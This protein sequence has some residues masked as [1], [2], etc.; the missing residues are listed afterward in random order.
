MLVRWRL[1]RRVS[2]QHLC[3]CSQSLDADDIQTVPELSG[4]F[5]TAK[6]G[7]GPP[8]AGRM[9]QP[10][11]LAKASGP[12]F[13]EGGTGRGKDQLLKVT[14]KAGAHRETTRP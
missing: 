11:S 5:S 4:S 13:S 2:L 3:V 8:K 9:G 1:T 14:L 6:R 7:D 10:P 12:P